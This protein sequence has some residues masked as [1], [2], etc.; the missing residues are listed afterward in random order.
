[1]F[2]EMP[3]LR[4]SFTISLNDALKRNSGLPSFPSFQA[5]LGSLS[6][7]NLPY[8]FSCEEKCSGR[9]PMM[10]NVRRSL[11]RRNKKRSCKR[12]APRDRVRSAVN[13]MELPFSKSPISPASMGMMRE[14]AASI[15][16]FSLSTTAHPMLLVPRSSPNIFAIIDKVFEGAKIRVFQQIAKLILSVVGKVV[17]LHHFLSNSQ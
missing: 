17:S 11:S 14:P 10:Y 3:A 6:L 9:K 2:C 8:L 7:G 15:H 4:N 1:M 16:F 12:R 13:E 5:N